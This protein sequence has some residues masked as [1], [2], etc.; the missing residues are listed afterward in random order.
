MV[1]RL[2]ELYEKD[3]T[4]L[5]QLFLDWSMAFDRVDHAA[6]LESLRRLG[7]PSL[8][9][10]VI[11]DLYDTPRFTVDNG[12]APLAMGSVRRAYGRAALLARTYL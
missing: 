4:P 11:S 8:Y 9:L 10:S 3:S 2:H 6:L 1:R 12:I 7:V 5:Y